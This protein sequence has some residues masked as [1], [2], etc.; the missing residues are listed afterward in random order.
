L[1]EDF[2][3]SFA[4]NLVAPIFLGRELQAEVE[5]T[6]AVQRERLY[7]YG[8]AILTAF[9]EVED[10]LVRE[11]KQRERIE[12]IN[13]QVELAERAYNQLRV[14]YLNG[15]INYLDVLTALSEVQQLQRD[16]LAA[17]LDLLSFRISLYR[18]LSGSVNTEVQDSQAGL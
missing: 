14:Q 7:D 10:A 2:A 15:A 6:E 1:F 16:Q 4:G 5:R 8:Q 3:L 13:K 12:S 11:Q 17:S 9:R 18:A